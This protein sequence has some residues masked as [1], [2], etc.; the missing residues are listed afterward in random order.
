ME[1]SKT[2]IC[3]PVCVRTASELQPA[4]RRAAEDADIVELRLDCLTEFEVSDLPG[5]ARETSEIS[6]PLI[7][8]FRPTHQGGN[9]VIDPGARLDFWR[10]CSQVF[11][12]ELFDIELDLLT[13]GLAVDLK[14]DWQRVICSH[15]DF[16][17]VPADL[18]EIFDAMLSTKARFLKI[19]VTAN[20]AVDCLPILSLLERGL[21]SGR[22]VIPI[23][24]GMPGF[25]TRVLG[26]SRGAFLT[27]AAMGPDSATAPGQITAGKLRE[28]YHVNSISRET[29]ILGLVGSSV[30]HSISPNV[31]N[32]AYAFMGLDA[33]Y[34]PFEV[35]DLGS[36]IKRMAHPRT[37]ELDWNLRG[38]GITAPHKTTVIGFLDSID[39]AAAE[40]GAVNTIV[41]SEEGLR[42]YNTDAMAVLKPVLEIM[43]SLRDAKVA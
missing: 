12:K 11:Q 20:D 25:A 8:T 41:V 4:L 31:H 10:H 13:N 29:H 3:I 36:F 35:Q 33:V 26:P 1:K 38:L 32:A 30:S 6:T 15:H 16:H 24:M 42:G 19:S 34:L 7:L 21:N 17:G 39:S 14:L 27:Y 18:E 37:R 40:I 5:L 43:G 23:A 22:E 9:R 28:I 2:R